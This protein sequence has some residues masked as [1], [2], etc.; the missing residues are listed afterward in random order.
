MSRVFSQ[1]MW[2]VDFYVLV[3]RTM[4]FHRESESFGDEEHNVCNL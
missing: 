2:H 4:V 1:R 3:I